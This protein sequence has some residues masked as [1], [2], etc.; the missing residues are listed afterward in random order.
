MASSEGKEASPSRSRLPNG[1]R[2][3]EP[4]DSY[5]R[6]CQG[7]TQRAGRDNGPSADRTRVHGSM[8]S[9]AVFL[10]FRLIFF[11]FFRLIFFVFLF[12]PRIPLEP[13]SANTSARR[14]SRAFGARTHGAG[15]LLAAVALLLRGFYPSTLIGSSRLRDVL[16]PPGGVGCR[17]EG[18]RFYWPGARTP[19]SFEPI[20]KIDIGIGIGIDNVEA[21][22]CVVADVDPEIN[23][24]LRI[25]TDIN[26]S[27]SM[28]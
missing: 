24:V 22:M 12:F 25:D 14:A 26:I 2:C 8:H 23:V 27:S 5:G 21:E 10:F 15:L 13:W 1:A 9:S 19:I 4:R 20:S 18:A 11:L 16:E 6:S 3:L 28:T 17:R 7:R